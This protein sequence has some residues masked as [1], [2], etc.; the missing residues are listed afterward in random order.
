M[1][2][3]Y[4]IFS[5]IGF[6]YHSKP[7]R[8]NSFGLPFL[9]KLTDGFLLNAK[10]VQKNLAPVELLREELLSDK[11]LIHIIDPGTGVVRYDTISGICKKASGSA[12]KLRILHQLV[13]FVEPQMAIELGT[14]LGL[15]SAS[16]ALA[17]PYK[18]VITVEG[19]KNL[20]EKANDNFVKLGLKNVRLIS[21][22]FD[23]VLPVLVDNLKSP[24]FAYVD[25]NHTYK[26]TVK[27]Y[28]MF[29]Q[30]LDE[31]SMLVFD[32]IC[33]SKDMGKAWDYIC[34][35][36]K[37]TICIDF[38]DIGVVVFQRGLIKQKINLRVY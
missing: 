5:A 24:F 38:Y 13:K 6:L 22:K 8:V 29:S 1:L 35:H 25:G 18:T 26:A 11:T 20:A 32:D 33:W 16:I 7:L 3:I 30:H 17:M 4:R 14:S 34:N 2:L 31:H 10:N 36:P 15:S 37:S 28:E 12:R 23:D 9:I 27:Y 21:Q 19:E